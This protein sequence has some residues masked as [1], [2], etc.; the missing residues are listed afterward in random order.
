M[1]QGFRNAT[2]SPF[3]EM[4]CATSEGFLK[5]SDIGIIGEDAFPV[6]ASIMCG[7]N[8][9]KIQ[10]IMC[11]CIR[12]FCDLFTFGGFSAE[13]NIQCWEANNNGDFYVNV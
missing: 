3:G 4:E 9:V 8:I 11:F 13:H 5:K 10:I 1:F 7:K 12:T 2:K 6:S